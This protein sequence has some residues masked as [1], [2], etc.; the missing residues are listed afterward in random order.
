MW[1]VIRYWR[2]AALVA[3]L[4]VGCIG[5]AVI[6]NLRSEL[7]EA[8][9]ALAKAKAEHA[10]QR[11]SWEEASRKSSENER[12]IEQARLERLN[13]EVTYA[14]NQ[15]ANRAVQ[16]AALQR[17]HVELLDAARQAATT[18]SGEG[19]SDPTTA[20]GSTPITGPGLVL[21]DV[22][23]R[24]STHVQRLAEL[25]DARKEQGQLCERLY[26][27]VRQ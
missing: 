5:V 8:R 1:F 9:L 25:A 13:K 23:G 17:A 19:G 26:D 11:V 4:A 14:K 12:A 16:L 3:L 10:E 7:A 22:L 27:S 18:G 24:C 21:T 20:T 6:G 2:I 15:A